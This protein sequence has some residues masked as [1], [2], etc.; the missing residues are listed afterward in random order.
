MYSQKDSHVLIPYLLANGSVMTD[1]PT[2]H[3]DRLMVNLCALHSQ[4]IL[5]NLGVFY[6]GT[7]QADQGVTLT[8]DPCFM[9]TRPQSMISDH[10]KAI[11]K[12]ADFHQN[13][14]L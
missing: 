14:R 13:P 11:L 4:G 2:E 9:E 3:E 8:N 12:M 6:K 7:L 10:F 1:M 5:Q